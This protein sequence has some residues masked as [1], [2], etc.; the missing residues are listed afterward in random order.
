MD[1]FFSENESS[2]NTENFL[3]QNSYLPLF[4]ENEQNNETINIEIYNNIQSHEDS[5]IGNNKNIIY[6]ENNNNNINCGIQ[7]NSI[8]IQ[9]DINNGEILTGKK[10]GR[11]KENDNNRPIHD[12]YSRDNIKRKI[13]VNYFNFLTKFVNFIISEISKINPNI[14]KHQFYPLNYKFK[15]KVKK[16]CFNK[17]KN[18]KIGDILKNNASPQSQSKKSINYEKSNLKIYEKVS[19]NTIIKNI[20]ENMYLDFFDIYYFNKKEINLSK[21]G[22]DKTINLPSKLGFYKDLITKNKMNEVY[23]YKIENCIKKDFRNNKTNGRT[24]FIVK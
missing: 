8:N 15:S 24:I 13:Q 16:D 11:K 21:F 18:T 6:F 9:I 19:E 2:M 12:K 5:E 17:L 20:L 4:P 10:R 14:K 1:H 23:F 3:N 7:S 22:L